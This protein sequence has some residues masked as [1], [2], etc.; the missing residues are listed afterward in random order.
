MLDT[1]RNKQELTKL[2]FDKSSIDEMGYVRYKTNKDAVALITRKAIRSPEIYDVLKHEEQHIKDRWLREQS[3]NGSWGF[4]AKSKQL[5]EVR[6][7]YIG[8]TQPE[9]FEGLIHAS[10]MLSVYPNSS[11]IINHL[12]PYPLNP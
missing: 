9:S 1:R 10:E 4:T 7:L 6:A 11:T 2:G 5:L 3:S 12:I 8:I